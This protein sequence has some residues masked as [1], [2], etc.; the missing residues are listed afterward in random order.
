MRTLEVYNGV[1][2][3]IT[4]R[5][6][7]RQWFRH[8]NTIRFDK[9]KNNQYPTIRELTPANYPLLLI[10]ETGVQRISRD[11]CGEWHLY[12]FSIEICPGSWEMTDLA[13]RV[14]DLLMLGLDTYL[15]E[16]IWT[17]GLA[18]LKT[19]TN[20]I[21]IQDRNFLNRNMSGF[22]YSIPVI[23]QMTEQNTIPINSGE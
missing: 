13:D 8:N 20:G 11:S 21:T 6:F 4:S 9:L 16:R 14:S 10:R 1:A 19:E 2:D 3:Y 17:P 7:V 23:V 12:N 15:C 18:F 22:V 5:E